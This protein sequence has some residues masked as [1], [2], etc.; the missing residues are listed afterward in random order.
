ME[1]TFRFSTESYF[2]ADEV[3][4][5]ALAYSA[6]TNINNM[7]DTF[8]EYYKIGYEKELPR[9]HVFVIDRKN[10][11]AFAKFESDLNEYCIG[12]YYGTFKKIKE[13]TEEI[14]Q[15][16]IEK[17]AKDPDMRG[18]ILENEREKWSEC[19]YNVSAK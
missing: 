18:L 17:S 10:I 19:V 11:N 3:D 4:R 7:I 13:K 9:P 5:T 16:I 8:R 6:L 12:I 1:Y 14:I 15:I 2:G